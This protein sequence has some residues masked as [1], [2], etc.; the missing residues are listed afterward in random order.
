MTSFDPARGAVVDG[1]VVLGDAHRVQQRQH[2]DRAQQPHPAGHRGQVGQQH[3]GRRR[4]VRRGVPLTDPDRVEAAP[5]GPH[6]P[7]DGVGELLVRGR[8]LAGD[9]VGRLEQQVGGGEL[10]AAALAGGEVDMRQ[11]LLG[12]WW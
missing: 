3:G 11:E 1:R 7:A 5:L 10:H 12:R 6:C 4:Q 8:G 2:R 9:Q